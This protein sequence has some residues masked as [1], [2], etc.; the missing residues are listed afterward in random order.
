MNTTE[1][2]RG[3]GILLNDILEG[4]SG[5]RGQMVIV[6]DPRSR[7]LEFISSNAGHVS[8]PSFESTRHLST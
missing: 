7:R 6:L 2:K 8:W 1:Q 3:L 4:N 5:A